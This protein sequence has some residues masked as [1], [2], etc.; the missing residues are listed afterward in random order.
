[1]VPVD[2]YSIGLVQSFFLLSHSE[3]KATV[4]VSVLLVFWHEVFLLSTE[5]NIA[6]AQ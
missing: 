1:M 4:H 2:V 6:R 3:K 5:E